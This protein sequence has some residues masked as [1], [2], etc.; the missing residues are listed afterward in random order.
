VE[1]R[2]SGLCLAAVIW[3]RL[4]A[5]FHVLRRVLPLDAP[6]SGL[7]VLVV[8]FVAPR[9]HEVRNAWHLGG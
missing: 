3:S 7:G 9:R 1:V 8:I 4:P 2:S 5:D 6:A